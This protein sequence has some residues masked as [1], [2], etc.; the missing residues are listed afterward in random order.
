MPILPPSASDVTRF[1]ALQS[2]I[3]SD[4][5]KRQASYMPSPDPQALSV[6]RASGVGSHIAP[7]ES[8]LE[9]PDIRSGCFETCPNIVVSPGP[10]PLPIGG[11]MLFN[12][13][14]DVYGVPYSS[15]LT[16]PN[17]GAFAPGSAN[18]S[19]QWFQRMTNAQPFPRIFSINND[20]FAMSMETNDNIRHITLYLNGQPYDLAFIPNDPLINAWIF[21]TM[22]R[23]SNTFSLYLNGLLVGSITPPAYALSNGTSQLFIGQK[24]DLDGLTEGYDGNL[25]EFHW[26]AGIA[27]PVVP[28]APIIPTIYSHLLLLASTSGAAYKDSGIYNKQVQSFGM[29]W[30][31]DNPFI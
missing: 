25:V 5:S 22:T 2:S 17:D 6:L 24:A 28:L 13:Q 19:I 26:Y 4:P 11:S 20:E 12:A 8:V 15:W 9:P 31:S 29:S 27:S 3:I 14:Q 16:V 10:P 7:R 23:I 18:F 21:F 1:R 30:V